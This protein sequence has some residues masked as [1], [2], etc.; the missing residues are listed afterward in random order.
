[1]PG[2]P[3]FRSVPDREARKVVPK[4]VQ[5]DPKRLRLPPSAIRNGG[6]SVPS[7]HLS[8]PSRAM[9]VAGVS[10]TPFQPSRW[11]PTADL[12]TIVPPYLPWK[13]W[14]EPTRRW[15]V[16][17]DDGDR[18]VMQENDPV[19][20]MPRP[21]PPISPDHIP[22]A[23]EDFPDDDEINRRD[24]PVDSQDGVEAASKTGT[25]RGAEDAPTVLLIHGLGG[26]HRSPYVVRLTDRLVR[27]GWRVFRLDLRGF[28]ESA[29][30]C[31]GH[32]HAGRG[33]DVAACVA[34][35]VARYPRTLVSV[36]G[37]SLGGNLTLR[38]L[39]MLGETPPAQF[40]TGIAVCPPID[41]SRCSENI[42]RFRNRLY[43]WTFTRSMW[44]LVLER[45]KQVTDLID[46]GDHRPPRHL[47]DFDNR[48][49]ARIHGFDSAFDYYSNAGSGRDLKA[50]AAPTLMIAADDDP[51]VPTGIFDAW[52]RSSAISFLRTKHGGHVG[53]FGRRGVD[54]DRWW[55]DWRIVG[56]LTSQL[57]KRSLADGL[58]VSLD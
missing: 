53:W 28:G 6:S 24:A 13:R 49:S 5:F 29:W 19:G 51:I 54:P 35:I 52:P 40:L 47:M 50:I 43:D 18:L 31:K 27:L 36:I 30:T 21:V 37:Y 2:Q 14:I 41:L 8:K 9:T 22:V 7:T 57:E 1:M 12:Q 23:D 17:L 42:R 4:C 44:A 32:M 39:S 38:Y 55:L 15:E 34:E 16:Q 20:T 48:F 58:H 33:E 3:G 25:E 46:H 45:R 56:W 11:L 10:L 26:S